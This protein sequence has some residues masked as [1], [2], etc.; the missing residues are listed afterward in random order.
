MPSYERKSRARDCLGPV[1][2]VIDCDVYSDNP[3]TVGA[4]DAWT[5]GAVDAC[6]AGGGGFLERVLP[7]AD[8]FPSL[9]AELAVDTFVAGHVLLALSIPECAVGF[10]AGIAPRA[11]VPKTSINE[12]SNLHFRK[13]KVGLSKQRQMSSPSRDLAALQ[14]GQQRLLGLL[15]ALPPN[16][17]HD[18]GAL[19]LIPNI[20]ELGLAV[21]TV[22]G[23]KVIYE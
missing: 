5:E 20:H 19:L 18:L 2:A 11:P 17:G 8:D 10:R 4:S 21:T 22:S 16:E 3:N 12:N 14:E 9:A 15:V 13:S 7:D 6:E 23:Q 1:D